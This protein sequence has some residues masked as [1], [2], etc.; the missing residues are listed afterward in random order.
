MKQ[1][2]FNKKLIPLVIS[3]TFHGFLLFTNAQLPQMDWDSLALQKRKPLKVRRVGV[4]KSKTKNL[5][6]AEDFTLKKNNIDLKSLSYKTPEVTT[7]NLRRPLQGNV[8]TYKLS[9]S[10]IKGLVNPN[11]NAQAKN[12]FEKNQ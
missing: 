3:I 6:L 12:V 2:R 10:K 1:M 4:E 5:N 7:Q 11:Q 9:G 8:P